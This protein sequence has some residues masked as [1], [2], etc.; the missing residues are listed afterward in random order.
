LKKHKLTKTSKGWL[1]ARKI[2]FALLQYGQYVL[3]KIATVFFSMASTIFLLLDR[4]DI[5]TDASDPRELLNPKR[6]K[7]EFATANISKLITNRIFFFLICFLFF[8]ISN[9]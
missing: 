3:E 2:S 4:A 7:K 5:D 6:K 8:Q 9:R 1:I